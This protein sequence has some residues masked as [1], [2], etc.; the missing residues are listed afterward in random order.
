MGAPHLEGSDTPDQ[1]EDV[2]P[3]CR[4]GW[5]RKPLKGPFQPKC[6]V[7]LWKEQLRGYN[8][9]LQ[10]LEVYKV[11]DYGVTGLFLFQL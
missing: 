10:R 1:G 7:I 2:T 5:I 6:S 8:R 11:S 3:R 9:S 4:E